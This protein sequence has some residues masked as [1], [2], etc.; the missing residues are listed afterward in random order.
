MK[1]LNVKN[2]IKLNNDA[3]S[4]IRSGRYRQ[5][6]AMLNRALIQLVQSSTCSVALMPND[7]MKFHQGNRKRRSKHNLEIDEGI[8]IFNDPVTL[9]HSSS[10]EEN[11]LRLSI[12]C[13]L[14]IAHSGLG[15]DEDA[16]SYFIKTKAQNEVLQSLSQFNQSLQ[17]F[18]HR[19]MLALL[20]NL[21]RSSFRCHRYDDSISF[22]NSA[23]HLAQQ[24]LGYY[25]LHVAMTLNCIGVVRLHNH[26]PDNSNGQITLLFLEALAIIDALSSSSDRSSKKETMKFQAC[27][28]QNIG[29]SHLLSHENHQA[30]KMFELSYNI[31]RKLYGDIH[32]DVAIVVFN[33]GK[34]AHALGNFD[35][36]IKFYSS[37]VG[38]CSVLHSGETYRQVATALRRLGEIYHREKKDLAK[39]LRLYVQALRQ[40]KSAM[41]ED[42]LEVAV[43]LNEIG[44]I[45]HQS[46]NLTRALDVYEEAF[47]LLRGI[48]CNHPHAAITI[49]NMAHVFQ[50]QNKLDQALS[51]Y[52]EALKILRRL[53]SKSRS[54]HLQMAN[55]LCS[56]G[57]IN[58]QKKK[59]WEATD[60][61]EQA[62]EIRIEV[63]GRNHFD[64]SCTLNVSSRLQ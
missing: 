31:R 48:D 41:S 4:S 11:A 19:G 24:N 60:A 53:P 20:H 28:Y 61:F 62:L 9:S 40:Y 58:D 46:D 26:S 64:V 30:K 27:V 34:A 14:G 54:T 6:I 38:T 55:V 2:A 49:I 25:H 42:T 12:Y 43:I 17:G 13:N 5:A 3:A 33:A 7:G 63:E 15:H 52:H 16:L 32:Y 21:G 50:Q 37:F 8:E 18:D 35:E 29:R 59:Y 23:L 39:A 44:A 45:C 47:N 56:I 36:S 22:Y 51:H 10:S 1:M 57:L